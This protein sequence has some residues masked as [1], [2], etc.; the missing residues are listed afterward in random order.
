MPTFPSVPSG[1]QSSVFKGGVFRRGI[2]SGDLWSLYMVVHKIVANY[3]VC[4][5]GCHVWLCT[6]LWLMTQSVMVAVMCG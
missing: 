2:V 1:F 5:G 6:R 4:N 3:L